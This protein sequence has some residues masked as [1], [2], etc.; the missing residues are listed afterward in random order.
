[1]NPSST[2]LPLPESIDG[3]E[4]VMAS[5]TASVVSS[6]PTRF[7]YRQERQMIWG[8]YAGDTVELGRFVG[9]RDGGR[10]HIAFAHRSVEGEFAIGEAV[11]ELAFDESGRLSLVEHFEKEGR[12]HTSVCV[13]APA[14][15]VAD[16]GLAA[17]EPRIDGLTVALE[18]STAS[19]VDAEAPTVFRYSER[20]G[21][22]WGEYAGDTVT[23]G[24]FAGVYRDGTLEEWFVHELVADGRTLVGDS[25]TEVRERADGRVELVEEFVLDGVPGRSVCVSR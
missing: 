25:R 7:R 22:A 19:T 24:R 18:S 9:R 6:Q 14:T 16:S 2:P 4:F 1:M 23:G 12:L 20:G 15:G 8:E 17:S 11:S 3:R 13:E 10:I 5:S 21:I